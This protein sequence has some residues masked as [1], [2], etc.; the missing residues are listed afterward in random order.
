M[1]DMVPHTRPLV[2]SGLGTGENVERDYRIANARTSSYEGPTTIT[3]TVSQTA[4]ETGVETRAFVVHL[5]Q[6]LNLDDDHQG[7]ARMMDLLCRMYN[8]PDYIAQTERGQKQYDELTPNDGQ[9]PSGDTLARI[10]EMYD[11]EY[12]SDEQS[13]PT[14]PL[15]SSI[16]EFLQG[17]G[18]D[19]GDDEENR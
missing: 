6:Y 12:G 16:E 3:Y 17:L 1:Y 10:E 5:P 19:L 4:A 15:P 7:A 13:E 11:N 14:T 2:V 8:L 9:I 18:A